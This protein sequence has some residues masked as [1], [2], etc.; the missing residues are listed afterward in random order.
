MLLP[1]PSPDV[2]YRAVND[3]AVL[4]NMNDEVY[5]GLN[6]VGSYIW[7]HLPPVLETFDE[8]C[9]AMQREYRDVPDESIRTDV[10]TLLGD[11]L[12][13]GLVSSP[14]RMDGTNETLATGENHQAASPRLG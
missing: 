3:G 1:V 2:I 11:L 8:L 4:L 7:E 13:N 10:R 12:T 6:E 9:A 14:A 5:Y